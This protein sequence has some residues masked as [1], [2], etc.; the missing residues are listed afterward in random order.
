MNEEQALQVIQDCVADIKSWNAQT[1]WQNQYQPS[2]VGD[3]HV[4]VAASTSVS[5]LGSYFDT[6]FTMA[7]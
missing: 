4:T 5:N 6:N 7:I 3:V 1:T 2:E